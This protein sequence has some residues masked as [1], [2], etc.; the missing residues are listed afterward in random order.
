MEDNFGFLP[1]PKYDESVDGY[2][3]ITDSYA[4]VVCV[5]I[6]APDP[7]FVSTVLEAMASEGY[8]S[9]RPIYYEDALKIKYS[10]DDT[11]SQIVDLITEN[12]RTDF[13]FLNS[14]DGLGDIFTTLIQKE[15]SDFASQYSKME[16]KALKK[17]QKLIE[18][19]EES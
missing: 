17:L 4:M 18:A 3:S 7:A 10:R 9:I 15:S 11:A 8:H 13:L 6:T 16:K 1:Y 19:Y 12:C 5:P 14:L 2:Y